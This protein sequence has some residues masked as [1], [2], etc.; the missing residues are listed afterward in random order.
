MQ[1]TAT[2]TTALTQAETR[3]QVAL[4][5][6]KTPSS[7]LLDDTVKEALEEATKAMTSEDKEGC[8]NHVLTLAGLWLSYN[9]GY[10]TGYV[11]NQSTFHNDSNG[12]NI[13]C[14]FLKE[15]SRCDGVPDDQIDTVLDTQTWMERYAVAEQ[16][17]TLLRMP[18]FSP[19]EFELQA[20]SEIQLPP[21]KGFSTNRIHSLE[22][23]KA[24]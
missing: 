3:L 16:K 9:H 21:P 15:L 18:T 22:T 6:C 10:L 1:F 23:E 19:S 14:C 12:L 17:P 2:S 8:K 20:K 24:V 11:S 5:E 13:V 7:G 4:S